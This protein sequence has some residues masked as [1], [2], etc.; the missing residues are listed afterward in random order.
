MSLGVTP[1]WKSEKR[2]GRMS[3]ARFHSTVFLTGLPSAS[4]NP[5]ISP[6]W[7][8][9]WSFHASSLS[10]YCPQH[11]H[12]WK[13]RAPKQRPIITEMHGNSSRYTDM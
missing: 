7:H 12:S 8:P 1:S 10:V 3:A 4:E 2:G 13:S 11:P 9:P 6:S 5:D